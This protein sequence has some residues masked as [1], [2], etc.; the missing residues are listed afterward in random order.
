VTRAADQAGELVSAL[1]GAG[2]EAVS[3]PGIA[4]EIDP[5]GGD[6]DAAAG[7]LH[8]YRWV[9]ITSANGARA[10]LEAAERIP[11]ELGGPSW[12]AIGSRTRRAL[13][14]EGIEV[15]FQPSRS[16][17]IVL[18][19]E[20]PLAPGDRVLVVRGDLADTKVAEGLRARRAVVDDVI[21][22]RMREAPES[23]RA[24]LRA[25]DADGPLAAVL[26]T[27]GST[28]RGLLALGHAESIDVR[29]LPAA[30]IGPETAEEAQAAGFRI[31][32]VSP[33]PNAAALAEATAD[34]LAPQPQETT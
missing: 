33:E 12:A 16:L 2:L 31:L 23:S 4:S 1:R 27:S 22:Y 7:L 10:I 14:H 18:A 13:E 17:G 3:V 6:L 24:M 8:T 29:A 15:A 30:C 11:T 21:G 25:A 26:F 32:A 34:A 20:L 5:R 28:V 9:V 19:A